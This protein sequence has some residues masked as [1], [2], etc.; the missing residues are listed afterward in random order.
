MG[1]SLEDPRA[2]ELLHVHEADGVSWLR[3]ESFEE[4]ARFIARRGVVLGQAS[5]AMADRQVEDVVRLASQEGYRTAAIAAA[6]G[7][8]IPMTVQK[9][10]IELAPSPPDP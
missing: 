3:K 1:R 9:T 5:A 6:L 7:D 8:R 2:R 4:L 10:P